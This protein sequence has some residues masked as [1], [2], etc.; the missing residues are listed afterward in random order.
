MR[1]NRLLEITTLLL[2]RK[3]IPAKEF[4]ERFQVSTRTIYRDVEE[5]S[6][7]GVPVYMSQG[8]GGGISLLETFTMDKTLISGQESDSLLLALQTLQATQ[9]PGVRQ[10]LAR[11]EALFQRPA[12]EDWVLVEFSPWGS[13]PNEEDKFIE[14]KHAILQKETIRFDYVDAR[15]EKSR[16]RVEPMRLI[17]KSHA[18]YLWGYCRE[19]GDFRTFRLSRIKGLAR[20]REGF[21]RRL[22]GFPEEEVHTAEKP[23][24]HFRLRFAPEALARVYD[25]FDESLI[26]RA[27]DGSCEVNV[28]FVDDEW[29][30]GFFLAYGC[31]MEILEP[32]RCRRELANRLRTTLQQ[33]EE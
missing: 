22:S 24:T 10:L 27:P 1:V 3:S 11:L 30:Y 31:S 26:V 5:L 23:L 28:D 16:R 6:A 7:A 20:T 25:D 14:I 4:A 13:N 21:V 8:K 17:F 12:A 33:Y 9:F 18:W 32:E 2:G 29:V 19:R 15:S